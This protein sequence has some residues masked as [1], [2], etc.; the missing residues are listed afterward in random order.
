ME[1]SVKDAQL[2]WHFVLLNF[3]ANCGSFPFCGVSEGGSDNPMAN[4]APAPGLCSPASHT[5][6]RVPPE[7]LCT[8]TLVPFW[9]ESISPQ[10]PDFTV[11]PAI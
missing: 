10:Y 2:G 6:G 9:S 3:R 1:L 8:T 4:P 11:R 5:L 7:I